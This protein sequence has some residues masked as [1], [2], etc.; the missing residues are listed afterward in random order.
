MLQGPSSCPDQRSFLSCRLSQLTHLNLAMQQ[1][2]TPW[3]ADSALQNLREI[4][5][6]GLT[7]T[8]AWLNSLFRTA[9]QL[10]SVALGPGLSPRLDRQPLLVPTSVRSGLVFLAV[11]EDRLILPWRCSCIP[12]ADLLCYAASAGGTFRINPIKEDTLEA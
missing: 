2:I 5:C 7:T 3:L 6:L 9:P 8:D 11:F 1:F 4:N 10:T 12:G